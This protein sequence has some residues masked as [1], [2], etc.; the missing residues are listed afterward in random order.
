LGQICGAFGAG[1]LEVGRAGRDALAGRV[2]LCD[3]DGELRAFTRDPVTRALRLV[4]D[5]LRRAGDALDAV[6]AVDRLLQRLGSEDHRDRVG[7]VL[8]VQQP[9]LPPELKLGV[10]LRFQR[11]PILAPSR[12]LALPERRRL[13]VE[14]RE[15]CTRT[16]EAAAERVEIE[17]DRL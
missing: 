11:G 15:I 9:Q 4:E 5:G 6:E 1:A 8:L 10:R 12:F 14:P 16:L 17:Q 7:L 3:L 2:R 13:L